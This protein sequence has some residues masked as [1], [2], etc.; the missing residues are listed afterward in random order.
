MKEDKPSLTI[1]T[2]VSLTWQ[3]HYSV[4]V[5]VCP[6][7]LSVSD[8]AVMSVVFLATVSYTPILLVHSDLP[9]LG[10]ILHVLFHFFVFFYGPIRIVLHST[11]WLTA[12]WR[13]HFLFAWSSEL[14]FLLSLPTVHRSPHSHIPLR[15]ISTSLQ[16]TEIEQKQEEK[17][18]S[19][20]LISCSRQF[21]T[22]M[23]G[24]AG[25]Y[26]TDILQC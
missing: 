18:F 5:C 4:C 8:A 21:I 3:Y 2:A 22:G 15:R 26:F 13:I 11:I 25:I 16:R 6:S 9:E 7:A 19:T 14:F 12:G 10:F 23:Y 20:I 24:I 1:N 17:C